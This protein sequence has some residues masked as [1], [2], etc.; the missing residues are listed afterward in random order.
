MTR[1]L[2]AI[3]FWLTV[4]LFFIAS[5]IAILY[6]LDYSYDW[7]GKK[8][9][10]NGAFYLKS[11]PKN[12][13]IFINDKLKKTT[14]RL[15]KKLLPRDYVVEVKKDGFQTWKKNLRI[16]SGLVTENKHILLIPDK[17]FLEPVA[18]NIIDLKN[19]LNNQ[20]SQNEIEK[21]QKIQ[22]KF[23]A[24]FK[25]SNIK[26][27]LSSGES[28]AILANNATSTSDYSLYISN[29]DSFEL[30]AE[31]IDSAEFSSDNKKLLWQNDNEIWVYWLD[32]DY[33]EPQCRKGDRQFITRFGEKIGQA[34]WENE[35]NRHIIFTVGNAVKII[36]L[37]D[38]DQKNIMN[39][40]A[41]PASTRGESNPQIAYKNKF[42]YILSENKVYRFNLLEDSLF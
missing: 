20:D 2:R 16:E 32:D 19:Y 23:A 5:P 34:I 36:E 33:K 31:G 38:R 39:I 8:L 22:E 11:T 25:L 42:L 6:A 27:I 17:P 21:K 10:Q 35:N 18:D 37:D 14:P 15:I 4:C 24:S 26:I 9:V 13:Q 1:K 30:L 3:I 29:D 41:M 12:A 28:S 40:A 7:Q